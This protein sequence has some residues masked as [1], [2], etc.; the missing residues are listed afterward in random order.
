MKLYWKDIAILTSFPLLMS[1]GQLLFKQ[2]ARK[3]SGV[4]W[5]ESFAVYLT[6]PVFYV[7]IVLYGFA[8]VL[9]L[10][11]LSRY[12]LALAY[13]FGVF[14]IALVPFLE[15]WLFHNALSTG[16]WLGL[17]LIIVGALVIVRVQ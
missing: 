10:W 2:A 4:P 5:L 8:T 6:L 15:S 12:S 9:W 7:A 13:P 17:S 11:I 1:V 16:Y 14:A 3:A